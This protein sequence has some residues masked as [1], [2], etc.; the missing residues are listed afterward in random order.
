M[1]LEIDAASV[2]QV[3]VEIA[4]VVTQDMDAHQVERTQAAVAS[5]SSFDV[6]A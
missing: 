1:P 5:F 2:E 3:S 4:S 6:E